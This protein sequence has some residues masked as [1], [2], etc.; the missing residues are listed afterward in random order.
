MTKVKFLNV[1]TGSLKDAE[2]LIN[3]FIK[4]TNCEILDIK[5]QTVDVIGFSTI[6]MIIYKTEDSK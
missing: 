2:D 1:P 4:S 6:L 3:R 5:M